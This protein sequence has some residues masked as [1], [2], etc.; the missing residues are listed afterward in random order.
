[1]CGVDL[2]ELEPGV[3]GTLRGFGK[4]MHERIDRRH[5]ECLRLD[6][7]LVE[8]QHRRRD[9]RPPAALRPAQC[10]TAI[11]R[12]GG[13][14]EEH[15]SEPQSQLRI[16]YAVFCSKKTNTHALKT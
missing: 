14:S 3:E 4:G 9:D 7:G 13:R 6:A 16:S 1:M 8:R 2:D 12:R 5:V 11:P 10:A 15:T